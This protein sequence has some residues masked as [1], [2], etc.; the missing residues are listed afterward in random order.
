MSETIKKKTTTAGVRATKKK[1]TPKSAVEI[2]TEEKP[3]A[4][5]PEKEGNVCGKTK[6]LFV[7]EKQ[8]FCLNQKNSVY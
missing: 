3:L 7:K 5:V 4:P 8:L 2:L 1:N 6:I